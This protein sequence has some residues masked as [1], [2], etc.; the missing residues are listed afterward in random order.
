MD[1]LLLNLPLK[2]QERHSTRHDRIVASEILGLPRFNS[3]VC[4]KMN[5]MKYGYARVS[6][7]DQKPALQLDAL[8]RA[9]CEKS[10]RMMAYREPSATAL[11]SCV[12]SRNSNAAIRSLSG[13]STG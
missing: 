11:P 5:P 3:K 4:C 8:K 7:D 12:V 1:E 2:L 10:S 9:G 6:T 13:N